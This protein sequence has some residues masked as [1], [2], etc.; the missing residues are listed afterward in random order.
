MSEN[1][2]FALTSFF[3]LLFKVCA[4]EGEL[5][6][7]PDWPHRRSPRTSV[8]W[9]GFACLTAAP[10]FTTLRVR[11]KGFSSCTLSGASANSTENSRRFTETYSKAGVCTWVW[12]HVDGRA[13]VGQANTEGREKGKVTESAWSEWTATRTE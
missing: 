7:C 12:I 2:T 13:C 10:L 11:L 5:S 3:E 4:E 8:P 9:L 6:S 1:K